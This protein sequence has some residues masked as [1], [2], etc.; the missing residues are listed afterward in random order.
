MGRVTY[1][2]HYYPALYFAILV[3]T[4]QIDHITKR[5][6]KT[7]AYAIYGILYSVVIGLFVLYIPIV[8]GMVGKAEQYS[9][10]KWF[11]STPRSLEVE[12]DYA[13]W[14]I[15]QL[16]DRVKRR[17]RMVV[18]LQGGEWWKGKYKN[19]Y[20][21]GSLVAY[22]DSIGASFFIFHF[23]VDWV[24]VAI[25]VILYGAFPSCTF[26]QFSLRG[27]VPIVMSIPPPKPQSSH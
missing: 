24:A 22:R 3:F 11:V 23:V 6:P 12:A 5:I 25:F 4:F 13:D 8:F 20:D 10:L 9:Y 1:V 21:S 2:H 26:T 16:E 7:V 27:L 15:G 18:Y 19:H 14:M 17:L